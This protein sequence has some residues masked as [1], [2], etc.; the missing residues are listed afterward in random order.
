MRNKQ[1]TSPRCLACTCRGSIRPQQTNA[2]AAHPRSTHLEQF[3]TQVTRPI[4]LPPKLITCTSLGSSQTD[5]SPPGNAQVFVAAFAGDYFTLQGRRHVIGFASFVDSEGGQRKSLLSQRE[6][7][8]ASVNTFEP[9]H[10]PGKIGYR[11]NTACRAGNSSPPARMSGDRHVARRLVH[12]G[13]ESCP[14]WSRQPGVKRPCLAVCP[15]A[16]PI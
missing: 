5:C 13:G 10:T 2:A 3:A 4:L 7:A 15:A 1:S 12:V 9:C 16:R 11:K 6:T 14:R 8:F